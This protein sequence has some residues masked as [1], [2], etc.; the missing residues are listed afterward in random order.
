MSGGPVRYLY[1]VI[2]D[3]LPYDHLTDTEIYLWEKYLDE[4]RRNRPQPDPVIVHRRR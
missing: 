1:E 4:K 2:P 3:L